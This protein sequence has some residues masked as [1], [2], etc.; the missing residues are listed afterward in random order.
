MAELS[1]GIL[2]EGVA[3]STRVFP[4]KIP[5]EVKELDGTIRHPSGFEPPTPETDF[6]PIASKT[7]NVDHPLLTTFKVSWEEVLSPSSVEGESI[8]YSPSSSSRGMR[9]FHTSAPVR[10]TTVDHPSIHPLPVQPPPVPVSE[11]IATE[12]ATEAEA[13]SSQ[14]NLLEVVDEDE[15]EALLQAYTRMP[16]PLS[17]E[18]REEI[19]KKYSEELRRQPFWRPMLALTFTTRPMALTIARLSRG[20]EKGLPYYASMENDDRKCLSSYS[21]RMRSMRLKRMHRL[22]MSLAKALAGERGGLLGVR[23]N[24][25]ERPRGA[26]GAGLEKP[27][28]FE[29][30]MI[31]VG[32]GDWYPLAQ[33]LKEN[34]EWDA[35]EAG[36]DAFKVYGLDERGLR[37]D[38]S[39]W[40]E[41]PAALRAR[42]LKKQA[43]SDQT[44][45]ELSK[46]EKARR[47]DALAEQ[48]M[49]AA[50]KEAARKHRSV[51]YPR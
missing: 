12:V 5:V 42:T 37:T 21:S 8:V 10:A 50:A 6:H 7:P 47:M 14:T 27:I 19:R 48:N 4:E 34:F 2:S 9:G 36:I 24:P 23:F 39:S 38:G 3:A 25:D 20:L 22:T 13:D 43:A 15:G 49:E 33:E 51:Y 41:Q 32:V 30:R 1:A 44:W 46:K 45:A 40:P 28:E 26:D 31:E 35:K 29:Q 17:I 18:E 16:E 11:D